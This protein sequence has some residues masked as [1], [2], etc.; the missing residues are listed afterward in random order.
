[1]TCNLSVVH[2]STNPS[3]AALSYVWGSPGDDQ[4]LCQGKLL[5]ITRNCYSAIWHLRKKLGSFFIW[6][7]AVCIDQTND[8][9]KEQQMALM[10]KIYANA[11]NVY[12]WLG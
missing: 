9:E 4:L 12:I 8:K 3:Y 6:V 1:I 11:K 10:E 2:L 5:P 7:D